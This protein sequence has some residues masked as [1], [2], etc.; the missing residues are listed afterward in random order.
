MDYP[1]CGS[2][3]ISNTLPYA[4]SGL[5]LLR[6]RNGFYLTPPL[7]FHTIRLPLQSTPRLFHRDLLMTMRQSCSHLLHMPIALLITMA[8]FPD[9]LHAQAVLL[10]ERIDLDNQIVD[11]NA[12]ASD[13]DNSI[14]DP[15]D[16]AGETLAYALSYAATG[17]A[18]STAQSEATNIT[19]HNSSS[20]VPQVDITA[21]VDN[22]AGV[23]ETGMYQLTATAYGKYKVAANSAYPNISSGEL[24]SQLYVVVNGWESESFPYT[25]ISSNSWITV[26]SAGS[27]IHLQR[28]D[29]PTSWGW[30]VSGVLKNRGGTDIIVN[31]FLPDGAVNEF[32][33][34]TQEVA[35]DDELTIKAATYQEGGTNNS[36]GATMNRGFSAS[37]SYSIHPLP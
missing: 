31:E 9:R 6:N 27:H 3:L 11:V 21:S 35:V 15:N 34:G 10:N 14:S 33:F 25:M 37:S 36:G 2:R 23:G 29:T 17:S 5:R 4:D 13:F 30:A 16:D 20:L 18:H 12:G 22:D 24:Q 26:E 7:D 19:A 1:S 28:H 32:Y 8:M